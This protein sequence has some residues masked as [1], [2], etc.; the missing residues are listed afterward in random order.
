MASHVSLLLF[1]G[2]LRQSSFFC[3]FW[4]RVRAFSEAGVFALSVHVSDTFLCGAGGRAGISFLVS[5]EFQ[6]V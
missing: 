1:F 4:L 2:K 5:V 3:C 6:E